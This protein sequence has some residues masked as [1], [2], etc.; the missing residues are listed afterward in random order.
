MDKQALKTFTA[1]FRKT[2]QVELHTH[3]AFEFAAHY[4]Y[5]NAEK[6]LKSQTINT[7]NFQI[8]NSLTE[9]VSLIWLD[10]NV[11]AHLEF[12]DGEWKCS[13]VQENLLA[14]RKETNYIL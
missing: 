11:A 7:F 6:N 8:I 14:V 13:R 2:E 5:S 1:G 3:F 4:T 10:C 12:L 9:S